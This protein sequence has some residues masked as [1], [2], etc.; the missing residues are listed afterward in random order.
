M[1]ASHRESAERV[2]AALESGRRDPAW[3]RSALLEVPFTERDA[4]LDRVLGIDEV[5]DDGPELPRGSV[6]YLPCSVEHLLQIVER[7]PVRASDVFVDLGAGVGR[8]ATLV[9][10]LS[11]ASTIGVE[12]QPR[13]VAAARELTARL[14]LANVTWIEGDA[15]ELDERVASGTV[16]FLYCPFG[17]KQLDKVRSHL[18]LIA[19][20]KSIRVCC[21]D[22]QLPPCNF[23]TLRSSEVGL[24]IF[25]SC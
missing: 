20:A 18:E 13:L 2:R 25:Q 22:L 23:L 9:H 17:G 10:L 24:E 5:Y 1:H 15:A 21:V 3:F 16:F 12:I 7:A 11:G 6:P 8:A 4:W 14:S 19:R